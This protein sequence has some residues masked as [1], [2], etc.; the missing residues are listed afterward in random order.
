[1]DVDVELNDTFE[2]ESFVGYDPE[3]PAAD[4]FGFIY[5]LVTVET[6][7]VIDIF[8]TLSMESFQESRPIAILINKD[9]YTLVDLGE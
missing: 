7:T 1:M 6:L 9:E 3:D 4:E 5:E 2:Y 8:A